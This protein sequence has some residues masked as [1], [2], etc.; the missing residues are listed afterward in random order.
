MPSRRS[1]GAQ[2]GGLQLGDRLAAQASIAHRPTWRPAGK[3]AGKP[4]RSIA[5]RHTVRMSQSFRFG[6][7]V[8]AA[9]LLSSCIGQAHPTA[10]RPSVSATPTPAGQTTTPSTSQP[11]SAGSTAPPAPGGWRIGPQAVRISLIQPTGSSDGIYGLEQIGDSG[12]VT[13]FRLIRID[14]TTL[15]VTRSSI[16]A[17]D[18]GS[19]TIDSNGTIYVTQ[20]RSRAVRRF[21]TATL[22]PMGSWGD[23][24]APLLGPVAVTRSG[25]WVA[26]THGL[27]RLLGDKE[28]GGSSPERWPAQP[29]M[30]TTWD[31]ADQLGDG[32]WVAAED[33]TGCSTLYFATGP[34]GLGNNPTPVQHADCALG[35]GSLA[36]GPGL[37]WVSVPTG[38]SAGTQ[39]LKPN[40][41]TGTWSS[42]HGPG[43]SNAIQPSVA[44]G[45]SYLSD[46]GWL[47]CLDSKG[48]VL[49]TLRLDPQWGIVKV[50]HAGD[51]DFIVFEQGMIGSASGPRVQPFMPSTACR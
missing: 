3:L 47:D 24:I 43:G 17:G 26:D 16:I 40:A 4:V 34:S 28:T 36:A 10:M 33:R 29:V 38:M 35:F 45:I 32:F 25:L 9:A 37:A 50:V 30:Q 51:Q 1:R 12:S 18:P 5:P 31:A 14:P 27:T 39:R 6:L 41:S 8:C 46:F 42:T 19:F 21:H 2:S 20:P 7:F 44:N 49:A 48:Q 13:G 22:T 11:T 23:P 15:A